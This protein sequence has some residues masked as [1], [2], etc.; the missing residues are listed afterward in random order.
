MFSK[1]NFQVLAEWTSC[2]RWPTSGI[3]S[4]RQHFC[5][6]NS[7]LVAPFHSLVFRIRCRWVWVRVCAI[8]ISRKSKAKD[9]TTC[10][11]TKTTLEFWLVVIMTIS[12]MVPV[13]VA[14][15][16]TKFRLSFAIRGFES[17]FF[18]RI[19]IYWRNRK[20]YS[21]KYSMHIENDGKW[22]M[23]KKK[24]RNFQCKSWNR[25]FPFSVRIVG[26]RVLLYIQ[27]VK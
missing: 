24:T 11:H 1:L 2:R 25:I 19:R 20:T 5:T 9:A 14:R 6:F 4:I 16:N 12:L 18:F 23:D 21:I 13:K 22:K 10:S 15:T 8:R 17:N 7:H 3:E 26:S 27:N